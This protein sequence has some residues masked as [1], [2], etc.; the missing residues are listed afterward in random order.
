MAQSWV[1]S[2]P[3]ATEQSVKPALLWEPTRSAGLSRLKEFVPHAGRTYAAERNYDTGPGHRDNVS[4]LSPW[5]RHRL[6][7]E[8]EVVRAV[9]REH[10]PSA[11]Q[12]F[13]QEVCWRTY[14]KGWLAAAWM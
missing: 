12:K 2:L 6:L 4:C 7:L 14:W 9:L 10:S 13:I 1:Y 11:A 3:A 5:I 8:E